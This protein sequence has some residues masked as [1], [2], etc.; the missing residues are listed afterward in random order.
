MLK[1]KLPELKKRH[2]IDLCLANGEN[3]AAGLG[4]TPRL[5]QEITAMGV[6]L[7]TLGNH[8]WFRRELVERI[9]TLPQVIRPANGPASWPGRGFKVVNHPAGKVLVAN[10]LGRVFMEPLHDPFTTMDQ[11]LQQTRQDLQVPLAVVD[12]HAEA[13]AEKMAL[14]YYLK[15]GSRR[16][17]VHIPMSRPQTNASWTGGTAY[18]TDIGMTGP[19]EGVIGM[20]PASSLRRLV[21]HLP[22]PYEAAGGKGQFSAVV[23]TAD[24]ATGR[25]TAIERILIRE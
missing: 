15:D 1:E 19:V 13:T 5:A 22:A 24:P 23:I 8:T 14:G 25:A 17:W 18:I 20:D 6:D 9:D 10:L 12:F 3:A 2:G 21:D 4:L 11:V 16:F 7:I